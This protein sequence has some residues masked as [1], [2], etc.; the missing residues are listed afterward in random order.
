MSLHFLDGNFKIHLFFSSASDMVCLSMVPSKMMFCF[1]HLIKIINSVNVLKR[2]IGKIV[3]YGHH[4]F[5][6]HQTFK[7]RN[8]ARKLFLK[9]PL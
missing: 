5:Q 2:K 4:Y 6:N 7:S 3:N 1:L 9:M 8:A